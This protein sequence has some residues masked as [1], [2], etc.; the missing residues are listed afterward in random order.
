MPYT[1]NNTPV[2]PV[3]PNGQVYRVETSDGVALRAARWLPQIAQPKGTVCVF[4]GRGECI[5]KYFETIH[6]LLERGFA[7]ATL[8]WR[9]QGKSQRLTRNH[10]KGHVASFEQYVCDLDGFMQ[11]VVLPDCPLPFFGLA[12]SMG[13][14]TVLHALA[15][16][17]NRFDRVV[18]SAP[19]VGLPG[20]VGSEPVALLARILCGL[21]FGKA[22][23]PIAFKASLDNLF[24]FEGNVVTRDKRRFERNAQILRDDGQLTVGGPT[25][26]WLN[27]AY[28]ATA[29]FVL[30]DFVAK[31]RT[32]VLFV[33]AGGDKVVSIAAITRLVRRLKTAGMVS[34]DGAQH[35]VLQETDAV[36][37]AFWAA[38]DAFIPGNESF[39]EV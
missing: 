31:I 18:L 33:I 23:I 28:R 4:Q 13:G 35:E 9:G 5:E 16:Y 30:P 32:P 26:G 7:V 3:P 24:R 11:H 39:P 36:R 20:V 10:L 37:A 12:H 14:T 17:P 6:G 34:L 19:M 21:G 1:L 27:A 38:F 22:A 15:R 2:N 29:H 25:F 8:D